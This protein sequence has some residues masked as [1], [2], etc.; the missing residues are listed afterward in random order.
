MLVILTQS[1][2]IIIPVQDALRKCSLKNQEYTIA[3]YFAVDEVLL[4]GPIMVLQHK[5]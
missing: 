4:L 1:S 3:V 5:E 2:L